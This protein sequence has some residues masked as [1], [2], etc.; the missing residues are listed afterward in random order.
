MR[1]R[2]RILRKIAELNLDPKE[3]HVSGKNGIL[4]SK[5][6]ISQLTEDKE[7]DVKEKSVEE[8]AAPLFGAAINNTENVQDEKPVEEKPKKKVPPQP[9]KKSTTGV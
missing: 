5:R 3:P 9:K 1:T 7:K 8:D 4:V 2:D 6:Q